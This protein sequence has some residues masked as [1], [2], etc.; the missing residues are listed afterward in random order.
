MRQ[1]HSVVD[2]AVFTI[3]SGE[4][5][6]M[7]PRSP[8]LSYDV[9]RAVHFCRWTS[10]LLL[11]GAAVFFVGNLA[12]AQTPE[13]KDEI[14]RAGN[15]F[16]ASPVKAKNEQEEKSKEQRAEAASDKKVAEVG[17]VATARQD[18][19]G[20]EVTEDAQSKNEPEQDEVHE[21][22]DGMQFV[23]S[24]EQR[25]LLVELAFVRRVCQLSEEQEKAI[26]QQFD[27]NWLSKNKLGFRIVNGVGIGGGDP[28]ATS[29]ANRDRMV[30]AISKPLKEI[31][32]PDQWEQYEREQNMR[33]AFE[34]ESRTG[35]I[36]LLLNRHLRL[37]E[38]QMEQLRTAISRSLTV[39]NVEDFLNN[40][41][42][43]PQLQDATITKILNPK[44]AKVYQSLPKVNFG[45]TEE[46][47]LPIVRK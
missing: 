9:S 46:D 28:Q 34:V 43:L 22:E 19:T 3:C 33:K 18:A 11:I 12:S 26:A 41:Q 27:K 24:R 20:G 39:D 16:G 42:Y 13:K 32:T 1:Y 38:S 31:L 21:H 44:Q 5:F 45:N 36:V 23:E 15:L 47:R 40:P 14:E 8:S 10:N 7:H 17:A 2:S 6:P 37:T 25:T 4:I 35:V 29:R 30:R